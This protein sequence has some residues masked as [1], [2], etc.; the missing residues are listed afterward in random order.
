MDTYMGIIVEQSLRDPTITKAFEI[1][2]VKHGGFWTFLL[3]TVPGANF[4]RHVSL[5]QSNLIPDG[6]W[7]V[8]YFRGNELVVV[9]H[10]AVFRISTDPASWGPA[11]E[12]GLASGIPQEQLDFQPRTRSDIER[13]FGM[14]PA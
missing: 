2:S 3:D 12:H 5:I 13:F 6:R 9:F 14:T 1:A 11:V 8:H 10:D 4:E 7:Y